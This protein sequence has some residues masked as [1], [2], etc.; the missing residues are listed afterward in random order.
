MVAALLK[1]CTER[2]ASAKARTDSFIT[3]NSTSTKA[4]AA[5]LA[6]PPM[7]KVEAD[8]HH[9]EEVDLNALLLPDGQLPLDV[10]NFGLW[11]VRKTQLFFLKKK[12]FG[13]IML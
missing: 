13:L 2:V 8:T 4:A 9:S 11:Y 6:P 10:A 7:D 3:S 12:S 5:K 1:E